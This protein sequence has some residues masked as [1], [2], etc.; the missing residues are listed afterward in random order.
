MGLPRKEGPPTSPA[1]D[2]LRH[3]RNATE[4]PKGKGRLGGFRNHKDTA[5]SKLTG[6]WSS[7]CQISSDEASTSLQLS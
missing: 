6:G 7:Q 1:R 2:P 3:E 5:W 4:Q